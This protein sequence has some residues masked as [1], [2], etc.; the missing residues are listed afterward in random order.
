[1]NVVVR[2]LVPGAAPRPPEAAL[3]LPSGATAATAARTLG[4][5]LQAVAVYL[6]NGS[7]VGPEA[8]LAADDRLSLI[9]PITGG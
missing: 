5:P 6:R 3:E 4:L 8:V 7:P 9:P 1:M 2:C